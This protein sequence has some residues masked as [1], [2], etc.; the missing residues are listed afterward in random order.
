MEKHPKT[1]HAKRKEI[2]GQAIQTSKLLTMERQT[3]PPI[4]PKQ[5]QKER[6]KKSENYHSLCLHR[7]KKERGQ[8]E[9]RKAY[10]K[11]K[12][13]K[14]TTAQLVDSEKVIASKRSEQ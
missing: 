2:E 7:N 6:E 12:K 3:K 9:K 11:E 4:N 13:M 8:K 1:K 14:S 10:L 5:T